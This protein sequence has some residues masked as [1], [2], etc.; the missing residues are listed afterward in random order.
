MLIGDIKPYEK[1]PRN[2]EEAVEKVANSIKEFGFKVPIVVDKDNVI[3]TGHTRYKAS[4]LLG[5]EVVPVIKAT[6]LN[7]K[8]I[9][10]FRVAD[11]KVAEFSLWDY[12]LL[13]SELLDLK[14]EFNMEAFGFDFDLGGIALDGEN[15]S[16]EE[17]YTKEVKIPQYEITGE[18][19]KL[20]DLLTVEK[21]KD[22][23]KEIDES[24]L[25]ISEK[26]F[27]K[28]AATRH[29]VFNYK[30]I[31]EYYAHASEE[32]QEF[33]EKSA[34]VIIDYSDSI[35]YGYTVLNDELLAMMEEDEEYE[36]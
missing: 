6:D 32:M 3:V 28:A 5:L 9:K 8:Q 33:M 29:F 18:K 26:D 21:A 31:A 36:E 23:S 22:L 17:R 15:E 25:S 34:L 7:P 11:N 16:E 20:T 24:N 27:L 4:Q 19:P 14:E 30:N 2:N 12:D 10:A 35:R 1:N 13:D